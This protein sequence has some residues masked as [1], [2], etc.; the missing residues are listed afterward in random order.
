[1]LKRRPRY[2]EMRSLCINRLDSVWMGDSTTETTRASV[3]KMIEGD[4]GHATEMLSALW[5]I[6]NKDENAETL[7]NASLG[8]SNQRDPIALTS[9]D[10]E[11]DTRGK[12]KKKKKKGG[13]AAR[14]KG[15]E[16]TNKAQQTG[17]V[18]PAPRP[19]IAKKGGRARVPSNIPRA[20]S[21]SRYY[22]PPVAR[23][24]SLHMTRPHRSRLG[25]PPTGPL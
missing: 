21:W 12:G 2:T 23:E 20:V 9:H 11:E 18:P 5:E 7:S 14:N 1:M 13:K 17:I 3:D 6:A 10:Q 8:A 19:E 4:L 24:S 22:L 16:A 25:A 15:G